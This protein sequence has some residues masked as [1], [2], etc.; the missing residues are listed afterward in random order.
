MPAQATVIA[1]GVSGFGSPIGYG[2][3][4]VLAGAIDAYLIGSILA[5]DD[6]AED[7][8]KQNLNI[9]TASGTNNIW[10]NYDRWSCSIP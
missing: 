6:I 9:R 8:G 4:L 7:L 2:I 10:Q 1:I 3:A 5:P